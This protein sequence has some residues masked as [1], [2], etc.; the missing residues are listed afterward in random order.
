MPVTRS[1]NSVTPFPLSRLKA[2]LLG[3]RGNGISATP[4]GISRTPHARADSESESRIRDSDS[5][6][7]PLAGNAETGRVVY[8]SQHWQ[9]ITEKLAKDSAERIGDKSVG[10]HVKVWAHARKLDWE[11]GGRRFEEGLLAIAQE[12]ESKHNGSGRSQGA[13]WTKM[14]RRYFEEKGSPLLTEAETAEWKELHGS[15]TP[16][17]L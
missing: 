7:P 16:P 13:M 6:F 17:V 11:K 3:A 15:Y 9:Q 5:R 10:F 4:R 14:V 8:A 12:L 1:G 2:D